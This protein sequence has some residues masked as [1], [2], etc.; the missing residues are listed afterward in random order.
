MD[1]IND[2]RYALHS[3][4]RFI[5]TMSTK[6]KTTMIGALAAFE[7]DFGYLWGHGKQEDELTLEE[8]KCR[9]L[10]NE[11]RT[12]ILNKGNN[13]LRATIDELSHYTLKWEKYQTQF[14][15]NK[16]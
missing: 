10:W 14:I 16:E 4:K 8:K 9:E 2:D 12:A 13:Q 6:F 11:T 3:K 7:E 15:I 5:K 1:N